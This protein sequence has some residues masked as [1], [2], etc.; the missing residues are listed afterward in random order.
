MDS[1]AKMPP[2]V[3]IAFPVVDYVGWHQKEYRRPDG[4][5]YRLKVELRIV[6]RWHTTVS[7]G[8]L[9]LVLNDLSVSSTSLIP[10][11]EIESIFP[12]NAAI[13]AITWTVLPCCM[14]TRI[15][16]AWQARAQALIE[17]LPNPYHH[18]ETKSFM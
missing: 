5:V 13:S 1:H 8:V 11:V 4:F 3:H 12:S 6:L 16:I 2:D 17:D 14:E 9:F 18:L 15:R 10:K 7:N